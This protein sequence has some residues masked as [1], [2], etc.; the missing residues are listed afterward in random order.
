MSTLTDLKLWLQDVCTP[1][2]YI[3]HNQDTEK[4]VRITLYTQS[5]CYTIT[6]HQRNNRTGYLGCIATCRK[7]RI[8]EDWSWSCDLPDGPFSKETWDYIKDAIIKN[9]LLQIF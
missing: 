1:N 4:R 8:G 7:I 9:E 5:Y 3:E 6:A 2:Q